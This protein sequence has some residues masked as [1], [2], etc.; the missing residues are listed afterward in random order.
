[1]IPQNSVLQH[2]FNNDNN[3]SGIDDS[4]LSSIII[5][6]PQN[7]GTTSYS[8]SHMDWNKMNQ[9]PQINVLLE[10]AGHTCIIQRRKRRRIPVDDCSCEVV[11]QGNSK[12]SAIFKLRQMSNIVTTNTA[13][14]HH[15]HQQQQQQ[16]RGHRRSHQNEAPQPEPCS[17]LMCSSGTSIYHRTLLCQ[18][19]VV[20]QSRKM[21]NNYTY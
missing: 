12:K 9:Q 17:E 21:R 1:M 15:H 5:I 2:K 4:V 11:V 3:G 10:L 14:D 16:H 18:V 6:Q 19:V 13:P 8:V 20:A 7:G